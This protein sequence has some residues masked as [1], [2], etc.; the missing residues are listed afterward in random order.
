MGP[1]YG[2]I[3]FTLSMNY[4][5][6]RSMIFGISYRDLVLVNIVLY[7]LQCDHIDRQWTSVVYR[8]PSPEKC[9]L[10]PTPVICVPAV[11]TTRSLIL[12]PRGK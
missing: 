8:E 3:R 6:G 7:L 9:V 12:S 4:E 10:V 5:R 2:Y 1:E 11:D